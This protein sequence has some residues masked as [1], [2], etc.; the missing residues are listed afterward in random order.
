MRTMNTD[1]SLSPAGAHMTSSDGHLSLPRATGTKPLL[2]ELPE[3]VLEL[4]LL[5]VGGAEKV[6][7]VTTLD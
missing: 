4:I 3:E 6:S 7:S 1:W 2:L 5:D